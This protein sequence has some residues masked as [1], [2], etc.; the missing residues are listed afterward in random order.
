MDVNVITF[1]AD[2]DIIGNDEPLVA[3]FDFG[4]K[5]IVF[6]KPK[7]SINHLKSLF[8]R[9]HID[10]IPIG[11]MQINVYLLLCTKGCYNG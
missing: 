4:P 2:Y 9:D 6:T 1:L 10:E 7:E 8:G 5:E 3:Q 11:S